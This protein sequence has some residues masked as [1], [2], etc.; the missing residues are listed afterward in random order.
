LPGMVQCQIM[1][2]TVPSATV[3]GLATKPCE[4]RDGKQIRNSARN[5][6]YRQGGKERG[7]DRGAHVGVVLP[8]GLAL[9]GEAA[10]RDSPGRH[11]ETSCGGGG[12]GDCSALGLFVRGGGSE[13]KRVRSV[14]PSFVYL[15]PPAFSVDRKKWEKSPLP[16][17]LLHQAS[18]GPVSA[19]PTVPV[20]AE[21]AGKAPRGGP[22]PGHGKRCGTGSARHAARWDR[23]VG[24]AVSLF[25]RL[26]ASNIFFFPFG[27][28][29]RHRIPYG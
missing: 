28:C 10:A 14:V 2:L 5:L 4:K 29:L 12:G 7:A 13:V 8:P 16:F 20:R 21:V 24:P 17:P 9:L 6:Q 25:L 26:Y 11:G 19:D 1:R 18:V 3:S 15:T 27:V 22:G 23:T